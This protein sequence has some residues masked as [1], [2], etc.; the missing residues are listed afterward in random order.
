MLQS[1]GH[2]ELDTTEQ[3][4]WTDALNCAPNPYVEALTPNVTVFVNRFQI[5]ITYKEAERITYKEA[6]IT[7]ERMKG[8]SQSKNNTQLWL[9]IEAKSDAVKRNIA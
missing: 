8:W 4:N 6:E 9:L 3:L 7:P 1:R 5:W 2:K